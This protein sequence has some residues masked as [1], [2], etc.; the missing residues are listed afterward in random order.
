MLCGL[1]DMSC[2][3]VIHFCIYELYRMTY[4]LILKVTRKSSRYITPWNCHLDGMGNLSHIGYISSTALARYNNIWSLVELFLVCFQWLL[5][6]RVILGVLNTFQR[7]IF[8]HVFCL[9]R[10][11]GNLDNL[12]NWMHFMCLKCGGLS[13]YWLFMIAGRSV[14]CFNC[15]S[16]WSLWC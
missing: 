3:L 11:M 7:F 5:D 13:L 9:S 6:S 12:F 8:A 16:L 1:S 10:W 15:T 4:K 2:R 14:Y